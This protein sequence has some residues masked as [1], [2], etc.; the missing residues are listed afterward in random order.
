M[1]PN[2]Y[3]ACYDVSRAK[4][5]GMSLSEWII[6]HTGGQ[7]MLYLI[8][9]M[10]PNVDLARYGVSR[11]KDLDIWEMCHKYPYFLSKKHMI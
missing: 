11:A 9:S 8:C 3:L 6:D 1:I 5:L 10:I 4:N 7:T 2:V